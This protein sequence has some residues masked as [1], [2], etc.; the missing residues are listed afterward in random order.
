[1]EG[2]V[3]QVASRTGLFGS[4]IGANMLAAALAE[5]VGT[6]ISSG[7][8]GCSHSARCGRRPL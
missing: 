5:A 2:N 8:G 3:T 1:L 7:Q 6:F 4:N